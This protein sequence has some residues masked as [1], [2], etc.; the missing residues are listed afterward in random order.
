MAASLA[1]GA[2]LRPLQPQVIACVKFAVALGH[3]AM[4]LKADNPGGVARRL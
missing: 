3:S 2:A 1:K 4:V